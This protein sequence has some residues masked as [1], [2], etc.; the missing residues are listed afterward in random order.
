[1][2]FARWF[3]WATFAAGL[4]CLTQTPEP[5]AK[6]IS[7]P[8]VS[9]YSRPDPD[10][11]PRR[12]TDGRI[13][14]WTSESRL[15]WFGRINT[16][17]ELSLA[18]EL[19]DS[20]PADAELLFTVR[21]QV[22]EEKLIRFRVT[23]A[24]GQ[25]PGPLPLG[26]LTISRPG[27]FRFTLESATLSANPLP[28]LRALI[29]GGAAGVGAQFSNVER[30]N[31]SSVHLGYP[32]PDAAKNEIEW[33]YV[34]LTPRTDPLYSYYMATGFSRGYFGMQVNHPDERRVI[35]SVWD[36]GGEPTDRDK[37]AESDRVQLVAKGAGVIAKDFGNEGTGGH[38]HLKYPWK[39][40]G[41][42]RFLLHAAPS[43]AQATATTY[44][45][46]FYFEE[47]KNW[48][49]IASFRAPRDGKILRGLYSFNENFGGSNGDERRL[50]EFGNGWVRARSGPWL[51]LLQA[52]FTHDDHGKEQRLDRS[53]GVINGRFYLANGGFVDDDRPG[54]VTRAYDKLELPAPEGEH[55]SDAQ[56][57]ALLADLAK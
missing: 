57:R 24:K 42:F 2:H 34:E 49:L 51:P 4:G 16:T 9:A 44:S 36:S 3:S 6:T 41:T 13:S 33:F 23:I 14:G 50:C 53:A 39:L 12:D 5:G 28:S 38:S 19:A 7:V 43:E 31:A 18:L 52:T 20:A 30:R 11:G 54:A 26:Q 40:G 47:K 55:P 1:M 56:L 46:W 29:L 48:G 35:F 32:V 22:G 17:G 45:A 37:V 8:A 25:G 10:R 27:Y 15:E 21:P